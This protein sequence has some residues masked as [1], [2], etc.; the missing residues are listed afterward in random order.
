M[1]LALNTGDIN[2]LLAALNDRESV[3]LREWEHAQK[4]LPFGAAATSLMRD[5][6]ELR[7]VSCVIQAAYS[8]SI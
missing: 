2:L 5:L 6:N 8:A 1:N 7:R 4:A 3:L